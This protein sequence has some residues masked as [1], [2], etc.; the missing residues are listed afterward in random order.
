M[1]SPFSHNAMLP[2]SLPAGT[3]QIPALV[4]RLL[5]FFARLAVIARRH[6]CRT[7]VSLPRHTRCSAHP[8]QCNAQVKHGGYTAYKNASCRLTKSVGGVSASLSFWNIRRRSPSCHGF[9]RGVSVR[10]SRKGATLHYCQPPES[11]RTPLYLKNKPG[12]QGRS[13]FFL[14]R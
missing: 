9:Y 8:C 10:L 7:R 5:R 14:C 4:H 11:N 3:A 2:L 12:S 13:V 1:L 6:W